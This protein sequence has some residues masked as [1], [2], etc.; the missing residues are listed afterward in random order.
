M[1]FRRGSYK[2]NLLRA[3]QKAGSDLA[4]SS[5]TMTFTCSKFKDLKEI[6]SVLETKIVPKI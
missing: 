6:F 4:L 5:I 3:V 2:T 1:Y